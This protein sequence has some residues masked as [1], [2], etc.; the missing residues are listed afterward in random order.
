MFVSELI[1]F[2]LKE[3]CDFQQTDKLKG[4]CNKDWNEGIKNFSIFVAY[5]DYRDP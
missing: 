2:K 4:Q 1:Q 5:F 3:V